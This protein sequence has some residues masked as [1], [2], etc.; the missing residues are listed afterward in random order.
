MISKT[1]LTSR[2]LA[3]AT[4]VALGASLLSTAAFA[5]VTPLGNLDPPSAGSY[6]ETVPTGGF[7]VEG[8]FDLSVGALAALS[9]TIATSSSSSYT[10]GVL[11]LFEGATLVESVPL[12]FS[13][14]AY[15]ASFTKILGP[16][17][18]TA[19]ITGTVNVTSLG[20]GGTVSTSAVPE[21]STWAMM[22]LGFIGLS[23]AASRRNAKGRAPAIAI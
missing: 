3:S 22:A 9:A 13:G 5:G 20:V 7:T 8:T 19:E 16:G 6:N 14:S 18:Y 10:P 15:A 17:D 4:A 23:Y 2:F 12:A 21:P 11:E 1:K